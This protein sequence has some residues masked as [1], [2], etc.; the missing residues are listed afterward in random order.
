[1]RY[2]NSYKTETYKYNSSIE[3]QNSVGI[4]VSNDTTTLSST[5]VLYQVGHTTVSSR[6]STR[7]LLTAIHFF[8]ARRGLTCSEI[9]WISVVCSTDLIGSIHVFFF[10][11]SRRR[12]TRSDRVWSSDVCSSDLATR[13]RKSQTPSSSRC[14]RFNTPRRSTRTSRSQTS[15]KSSTR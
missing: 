4:N 5:A 2:S 14:V 13:T 10:F 1:M 15:P 8:T 11:S 7:T 9:E 3:R 12:H 6:C